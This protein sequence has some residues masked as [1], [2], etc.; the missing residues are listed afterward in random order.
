[1]AELEQ[2]VLSEG[3]AME[4]LAFLITAARTMV[5]E[6]LDYGPMR[7]L[8]AAERMSL[9]MMD[10]ATP[11]MKEFLGQF[12]DELPDINSVRTS[13]PQK[14]RDGLDHLCRDLAHY[15]V[16]DSNLPKDAP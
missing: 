4:L 13:D 16:Q 3:E 14:Y 9:L 12:L 6:P 2:W 7:L 8:T 15:L 10:R 11:S 5:D 1:M